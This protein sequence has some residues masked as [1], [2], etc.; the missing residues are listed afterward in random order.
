M[1]NAVGINSGKKISDGLVLFF[2]WSKQYDAPLTRDI[3]KDG[4]VIWKAQIEDLEENINIYNCFI[5]S[6][7]ETA[8]T[9]KINL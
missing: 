1:R 7:S 6:K 5:F 9:L 2:S 8:D 3:I 4:H